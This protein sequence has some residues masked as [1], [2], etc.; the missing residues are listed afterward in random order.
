MVIGPVQKSVAW[1]PTR[2]DGQFAAEPNRGWCHAAQAEITTGGEVRGAVRA[3]TGNA[4]TSRT[5]HILRGGR[6]ALSLLS[7][8]VRL[9]S[10]RRRRSLSSAPP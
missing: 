5:G 2:W 9:E 1:S 8:S 7:L 10:E 4:A 3:S 6:I